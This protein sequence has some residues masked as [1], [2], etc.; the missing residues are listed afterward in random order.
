VP[1]APTAF[2]AEALPT[3]T[4]AAGRVRRSQRLRAVATVLGLTSVMLALSAIAAAL[5]VLRHG[6]VA[7]GKAEANLTTVLRAAEAVYRDTGQFS[8]AT[9]STLQPHTPG[10]VVLVASTPSTRAEQ[11]S[12]AIA[13]DG[14]F[15]AVRSATG[16]CFAAGTVRAY[17]VRLQALLPGNCTGDAA[18]ATLGPVPPPTASI[19]AAPGSSPGQ[20]SATTPVPPAGQPPAPGS[21]AGGSATGSSVSPGTAPAP[22][23]TGDANAGG[24][25]PPAPDGDAGGSAAPAG[26]AGANPAPA[27]NAV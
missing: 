15:G 5:S 27:G 4:P 17:S 16:R 7:D 23:S 12:M 25:T 2:D 20:G 18:R 10:L 6:S 11:I 24:G 3:P 14:W 1:L 8:S 21:A 22:A 19:T 13:D 26:G 9:P